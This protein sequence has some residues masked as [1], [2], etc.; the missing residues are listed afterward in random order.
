MQKKAQNLLW[1]RVRFLPLLSDF[2]QFK[3]FKKSLITPFKEQIKIMNVTSTSGYA[4]YSSYNPQDYQ[5]STQTQQTQDT[6]SQ[7]L[8]SQTQQTTAGSSSCP[9]CGFSMMA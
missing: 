6:S 1:L 8:Q 4:G 5:S 9:V 7:N 3:S 2:A